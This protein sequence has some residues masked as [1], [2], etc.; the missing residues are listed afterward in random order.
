MAAK[1]QFMITA[2]MRD[3]LENELEY[4]KEEVDEMKPEIAANVIERMQKRPF[5]QARAMPESWKRGSVKSSGGKKMSIGGFIVNMNKL[6]IFLVSAV[7]VLGGLVYTE[8]LGLET[9][10]GGQSTAVKRKLST[11]VKKQKKKKTNSKNKN[12]KF[13]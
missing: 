3:I 7:C 12:K 5:G 9:L 8:R 2:R 6:Q 10:L 4:A 11:H 13:N 1:V